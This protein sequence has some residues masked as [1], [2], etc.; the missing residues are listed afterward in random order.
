MISARVILPNTVDADAREAESQS[1]WDSQKCARRDAAFEAYVNLYRAGLVSPHLLPLRGYD[2]TAAE[3]QKDVEKIVRL[4]DVQDQLVVWKSVAQAWQADKIPEA[5]II[6]INGRS[7]PHMLMLLPWQLSKPVYIDLYWDAITKVQATITPCHDATNGYNLS[8]ASTTTDLLLR[9][10]FGGRLETGRSDFVAL[11]QFA[12]SSRYSLDCLRGACRADHLIKDGDLHRGV[13]IIRDLA[14]NETPHIFDGVEYTRP[15]G[16]NDQLDGAILSSED[17]DSA[18]KA[19]Y[20]RVKKFPKRADFLHPVPSQN[21]KKT[22]PGFRYLPAKDCEVDRLAFEHSQFALFIP[23]ITHVVE[24]NMLAD[25]LCNNLLSSLRFE[26]LSLVITAIS[27]SAAR[28]TTNYQRLEFLGDSILKYF[29]SLTLIATHLNW[30]EGVLSHQKDHIVSNASLARSALAVGLDQYILTKPFTGHK[31][32]PDYISDLL[33]PET[34]KTRQMSTKTL[35]DV[36]ESLIGA[37]YLDGGP[38]KALACLQIFL[39]S[40]PWQPIT[41]LNETLFANYTKPTSLPVHLAPLEPLLGYSFT[42]PILLIEAL[43]H[44]SHHG[45]SSS[46]QRLEFLGDSI[47]DRIVTTTAFAHDPPIPTHTLHL[48][49]TALV[50]ANFLAF[51]CMQLHTSAT[52]TSI[53]TSPSNNTEDTPTLEKTETE[54]P[55]WTF[56]RHSSPAVRSAQ[57]ACL[58]RFTSLRTPI[59][60]SLRSGKKYPWSLLA[61]LD[62]PKFF[63][64]LVESLLGAIYI[65]SRGSMDACAGFLGQL[66]LRAYLDRV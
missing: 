31:W 34:P 62:A 50:N 29:T 66:G 9:S 55:L 61:T 58:A 40:T 43:T 49:R 46:Y 47:L 60:E 23:S 48:I 17:E 18:E 37:A 52:K 27:A 42:S 32:R 5:S 57:R 59:S 8:E 56:M 30:H 13:G 64:D 33:A 7:I 4:M 22:G 11:F 20:L 6:T 26:D 12:D 41:N 15:K 39:P 38:S 54:L 16:P 21:S 3:A 24:V 25:H 44:S 65:D 36:V 14:N 28:E 45:A 51:L 10:V 63:S 35:A 2:E 53:T 19:V 1:H